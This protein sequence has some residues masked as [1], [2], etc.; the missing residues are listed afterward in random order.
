MLAIPFVIYLVTLL[1][2]L[3]ELDRQYYQMEKESIVKYNFRTQFPHDTRILQEMSRRALLQFD[4]RG[5]VEAELEAEWRGV[6]K[7]M[8]DGEGCVFRIRIVPRDGQQI[9]EQIDKGKF[10]RLNRFANTLFYRNFQ[11]VVSY[12]IGFSAENTWRGLLSLHYT[13][14]DNYAPIISLTNRYRAVAWLIFVVVTASHVYILRRMIHPT[15]RVVNKIDDPAS[16]SPEIIHKPASLLEKAYNNLARDAIL[17]RVGQSIRNLTTENPTFDRSEMLAGVPVYLVELLKYRAA[18]IFDLSPSESDELSISDCGEA[19]NE[20]DS[21]DYKSY[22]K[23]NIFCPP[24]MQELLDVSHVAHEECVACNITQPDEKRYHTILVVF[25]P[26]GTIKAGAVT[27]EWHLETIHQ[28]AEQLRDRLEALDLHS[29]YIRRERSRANVNLARNLG[30]DLT[31][32]IATSKLDILTIMKILEKRQEG[33]PEPKVNREVL[34]DTVAGLLN[35]T[36]LLQEI[37]NIY[38]SFSY[39]DRP[40]LEAANINDILDEIVVLF[41]LSLPAK[42]VIHRNYHEELPECT[43]EPRLIKLALFNLLTNAVAAIKQ[44]ADAPHPEGK[45]TVSTLLDP[46]S[47][48]KENLPGRKFLRRRASRL[49]IE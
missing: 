8:L 49:F 15:R 12:E 47:P 14:P 20:S 42:T 11:N 30:H 37:V 5:V 22:C 48:A 33:S 34:S 41:S 43:V 46:E 28:L 6:A 35:N 36:R 2:L 9:I 21:F 24:K 19:T 13:T 26:Y 29:K 23:E 4:T 7:S 45:I 44:N 16:S 31:N 38:R 39:I 27:R 3:S 18:L 1:L 10:D 32:I 40:R 17:L 25:P